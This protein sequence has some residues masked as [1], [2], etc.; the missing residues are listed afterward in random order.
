[1]KYLKKFEKLDYK[2]QIGDYVICKEKFDISEA[3]EE[4]FKEVLEITSSTIG[5]YVKHDLDDDYLFIQYKNIP[6]HLQ[7]YFS[8]CDTIKNCRRM[9]YS[10]IKYAS[11]KKENLITI[12]NNILIKTSA[13]KFNL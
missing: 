9:E 11:Q 13:N 1:M 10:E 12:L 7:E 8:S 4:N 3:D 2:I 5:R 6:N